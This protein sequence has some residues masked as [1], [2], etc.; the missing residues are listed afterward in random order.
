MLVKIK[1]SSDAPIE[2][3]KS[4]NHMLQAFFYRNMDRELAKFLHDYGF[5]LGKRKFKLFTFSKVIGKMLHKGKEKVVFAPEITLYFG[6]PL[7]S[8]IDSW[9]KNFLMSG[10][11][12][13]GKNKL[14]L[15]ALEVMNPNVEGD[16][17]VVRCL[18][19]ILIYRTPPGEKR[20]RYITPFEEDFFK[21]GE[22][23]LK[24]KFNI[25]YGKPYTD[26][27]EISRVK[28]LPS[29]RKKIQFKGRL[30]EAWLLQIKGLSPNPKARP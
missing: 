15:E 27:L 6:S 14:R 9:A 17:V 30:I 18:S 25:V 4:Y 11:L 28:V 8:L 24:K 26:T 16:E 22:E 23:N 7:M 20:Y 13:L 3:P 1:L 19:P 10:D 5:M 21:L 29:H 2:L 12:F